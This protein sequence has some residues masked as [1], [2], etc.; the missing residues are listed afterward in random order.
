[1]ENV[2]I[3]FFFFSSV[4]FSTSTS[5]SSRLYVAIVFAF[6]SILPAY[7]N[8]ILLVGSALPVCCKKRSRSVETSSVSGRSTSVIV[9]P[10]SF[11]SGFE[12]SFGSCSCKLIGC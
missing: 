3:Y 2:T 9:V 12:G 8:L 11:H 6:V 10:S 7:V 5:S 4:R 1:V